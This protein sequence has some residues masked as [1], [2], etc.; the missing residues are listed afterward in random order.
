MY[1]Y[2][3][4]YIQCLVTLTLLGVLFIT[5]I[6]CTYVIQPK[7]VQYWSEELNTAFEP[8]RDLS[9]TLTK[10]DTMSSYEIRYF[11]V[12]KVSDSKQPKT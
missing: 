2:S 1:V 10:E 4:A 5:H 3:C 6:S 7:C 9:V 11:Q 8:G 12:R